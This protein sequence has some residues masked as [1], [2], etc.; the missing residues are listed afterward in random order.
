ML[1]LENKNEK[2]LINNIGYQAYDDNKTILDLSLCN[3]TNIKIFYLIKSNTTIDFSF[4]STFK[5]LNI[6]ILNINDSFFNDICIP[7]S[8]PKNDDVVLKDRLNDIYQNYLLCEEG[9]VYKD[10]NIET[11]T[12]SCD[13]D[14]KNQFIINETNGQLV[15]INNIKKSSPFEIIK[16]YKLVFSLKN[17]LNNIGFLIFSILIFIY[18]PLLFF[19]FY[20][21][22]TP[23]KEYLDNEMKEYGYIKEKN[24]SNNKNNNEIKSIKNKKGKKIKTK[25]RKKNS[26]KDLK[27]PP[28]KIKRTKNNKNISNYK[29]NFQ[30]NDNSSSNRIENFNN[31]IG[32]L[33]K[34]INNKNNNK[35]KT[36]FYKTK[37]IKKKKFIS[38][39]TT[40]GDKN[41]KEEK[42]NNDNSII[43]LNLININLDN[44]D[45]FTLK[46]SD[47]ILN[48]YSFEEAIKND[49]RSLCRIYYIYLLAKQSIFHAFLYKSP[50]ELFPLRFCLLIF[51]ISSD[52]AL[53][54]IFYFDDKISEKYKYAKS[55]FLFAF[56]NNI[57][58]ILLSTFIGFVLLTLFTK[59]SN[60]SNQIR[61]IFKGEE[62]KMKKDKKYIVNDVRKK[63]I[64]KE[65]GKILNNYKIKVYIFIIIEI[66]LMLFYWYYVTI[67]CHVYNNT[68][69]SWIL[70]SFL[71]MLSR[72][73]IDF[74]L[75]LGFAKLYRIAVESNIHALY[76]ISLFFYSFC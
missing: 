61:D 21:G 59:L 62:E 42:L 24:Y 3:N 28:K 56:S 68:Q 22:I 65:I 7:Y 44:P 5:D 57:T 25:K 16:C 11:M 41:I 52:L 36:L 31:Y 64:Q 53:N 17:K 15:N 58:V 71:A 6:D 2:S 12:I 34:T 1:E 27:S 38:S 47:H 50:L 4:I 23:I 29:T 73:I 14:V 20:Q 35:S 40:Q 60:S 45:S 37:K 33:N 30:L 72:I 76:K 8:D 70:D 9:C 67:F 26:R 18:I 43:N 48:V 74:L 46:S 49:M 51:I 63:E 13:C 19:Y 32:Q 66:L 54:A 69:K 39:L 55:L 75:C 10:T